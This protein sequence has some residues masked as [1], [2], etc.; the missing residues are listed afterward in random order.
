M[1]VNKYGSFLLRAEHLRTLEDGTQ[2]Q[3]A[4]SFGHVSNPY[5]REYASF[6]PDVATLEK[7]AIATGGTKNP[8]TVAAVFDPNGEKVTY[9]EELWQRF[10]L[11]AIGVFLLD[12]LV[13]RVRI[14]D[15]KFVAKKHKGGPGGP[16]SRGGP[17]SQGG[18]MSRGAPI[19]RRPAQ[20]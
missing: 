2:K 18:P 5:P 13:R 7:A 10:V 14:F 8:P 17:M 12:L 11:A 6:E 1:T 3:V 4:V 16:M 9:H 15:R 20:V 19:S